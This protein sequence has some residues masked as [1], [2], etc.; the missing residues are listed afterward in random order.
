MPKAFAKT[1]RGFELK[2][3]E[4]Y[5]EIPESH[6][7]GDAGKKQIALALQGGGSHGAFTWGVLDRLLQELRAI[8]FVR[9][10]LD[11]GKINPAAFKRVNIH[12]ISDDKD[13]A[14]F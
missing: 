4:H 6:E 1:A 12:I 9:R 11:E 5:N 13:L 2:D 14:S 10:L 3:I 7:A 8:D